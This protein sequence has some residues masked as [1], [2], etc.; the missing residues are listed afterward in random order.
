MQE[1]MDYIEQIRIVLGI[2]HYH[3][4]LEEGVISL[5]YIPKSFI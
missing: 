3:K 1:A 4:L 2:N 5:V